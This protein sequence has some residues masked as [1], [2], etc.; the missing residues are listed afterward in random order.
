MQPTPVTT[1]SQFFERIAQELDIPDALHEDAIVQY[2]DV[3]T[4]ISAVD[5][6]LAVY[7]PSVYPQGSF[8]LGTVVRPISE[9]DHYDIDLVCNLVIAKENTSQAELKKL[10]G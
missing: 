9:E 10:L 1:L 7:E 6:L 4:W 3:A 8:R 2:E 5:S